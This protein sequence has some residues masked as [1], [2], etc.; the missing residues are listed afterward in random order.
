MRKIIAIVLALA[1][2][3]SP[4][5]MNVAQA[6]KD[7]AAAAIL[8]AV[9]TGTGEWYNNG[10]QGSFPWAECVVGYICF[11]FK[12]TSIMDAANGNTDMGMRYDFWTAPIK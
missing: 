4:I 6:E 3:V 8:S 7:P 11:C 1:F 2:L 12:L 10:W 5:A 9:M